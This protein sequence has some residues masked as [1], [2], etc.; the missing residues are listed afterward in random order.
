MIL[1]AS[2]TAVATMA[3]TGPA[4]ATTPEADCPQACPAGQVCNDGRCETDTSAPDA[5]RPAPSRPTPKVAAPAPARPA[6]RW[7]EGFMVIPSV[8]MNSFQ[9][10]TGN[11]L[12]VGLRLGLIAGSRMAEYWSL[13]VAAA[14]DF[15][16]VPSGANASQY[17][18]DLGFNPLAH[19]PLDSLEIVAGPILGTWLDK[20]QSMGI[21]VSTDGWAYGWTLGVDAGVLVPVGSHASIGALL[22]FLVRTPSKTCLT[23]N[24]NTMSNETC[25][26]SGVDAFKTLGLALAAKF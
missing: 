22:S 14:F 10:D 6:E 23:T 21:D 11:G 3:T 17:V 15:V 26:S 1:A 9:G 24:F 2:V 7:H 25:V 13:N 4:R 20:S 16:N 19:I 5:V 18:G 8:G 12:G